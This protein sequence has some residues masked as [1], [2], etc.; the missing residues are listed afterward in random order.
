MKLTLIK[1]IPRVKGLDQVGKETLQAMVTGTNKIL[2]AFTEGKEI[3]A[4]TLQ[5]NKIL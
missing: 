1:R 5:G 2:S 4:S 3:A